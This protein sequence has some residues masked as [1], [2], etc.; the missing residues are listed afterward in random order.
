MTLRDKASIYIRHVG[1]GAVVTAGLMWVS[2]G[3]IM[4]ALGGHG[5]M[6]TTIAAI[7]CLVLVPISM[8]C[9]VGVVLDI[10]VTAR[11]IEMMEEREK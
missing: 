7:G 9:L 1:L 5:W 2:I 3:L 8:A 11:R 4:V 10:G 6:L